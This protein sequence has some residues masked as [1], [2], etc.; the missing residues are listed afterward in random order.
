MVINHVLTG[1]IRQVGK[2]DDKFGMGVPLIINHIQYIHLMYLVDIYIY[3]YMFI[4]F[5]GYIISPFKGLLGV[6]NH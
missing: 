3:I 2:N 6:L 1:M 5:I 4:V